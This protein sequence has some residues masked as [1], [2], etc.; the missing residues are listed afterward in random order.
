MVALL[1]GCASESASDEPDVATTVDGPVV[2]VTEGEPGDAEPVGEDPVDT[3]DQSDAA[4]G[5][6]DVVTRAA[7]A[8]GAGQ[9]PQGFDR[10]T[11]RVISSEGVVCEVCVWLADDAAARAR[12]LMGVTDLGDAVGMAFAYD[13]PTERRFFMFDT[14]T[15]LSIAWFA[16]DGS[17]VSQADMAPCLVDDASICERYTA[18]A[19]YTLAIEMFQ[20]QLDV[21][22]IGPGSTV[23][24][25]DLPC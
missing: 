3:A 1:A 2:S 6:K 14:P 5:S 23:D 8:T 16:A 9:L 22:G 10:V 25:L 19:P 17:F 7:D 13:A 20:S 4:V 12:G 24:L 15:P 11:A 21:I 18:A